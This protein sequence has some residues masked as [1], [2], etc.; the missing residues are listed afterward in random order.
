LAA[1]R[2]AGGI[3][4][5]SWQS[6]AQVDGFAWTCGYCGRAVSSTLAYTTYPDVARI[7]VCSGCGRPTY[8]NYD[9]SEVLPAPFFGNDVAE[10]PKDVA[11]LYDEA[12]DAM[13]VAAY[14]SVVLA[15]RK[16]LMHVA[17]SKGAPPGKTFVEYVEYLRDHHLIP[18]DSE[19][20]VD[21]LRKRGNE[22]NHEIR[23]MEKSDAEEMLVFAEMLLK[24]TYE[25]PR[26]IAKPA[27]ASP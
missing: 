24:L 17:S 7:F 15:C 8:R 12:R 2:R 10:L 19:H 20:W 21:H 14:T 3:N 11:R 22:A 27:P 16:I 6:R 23:L 9:G 13:T 4:P 5:N 25:F 1:L 26:R 18:Q